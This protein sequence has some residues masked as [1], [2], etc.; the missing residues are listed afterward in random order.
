MGR[1]AGVFGVKG[2]VKLI[3]H[4]DPPEGL[5]DYAPWWLTL[6][7]YATKVLQCRVQ[8]NGLVAQLADAA[9]NA[10]DDRDRAFQLVGSSIEVLRSALPKA[11]SGEIYLVDLPGMRV[12]STAGEALGVVESVTSNG[13]QDVLVLR[14]EVAKDAEGQPLQRLIPFVRGA[15]IESVS[16]E[17]GE[18]VAHWSPEW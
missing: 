6:P 18:I 5:F 15:I 9:G 3:S 12:K 10:I 2:W 14:D 16:P 4:S 11:Q 1:I 13:A 17:A 8:G 7:G